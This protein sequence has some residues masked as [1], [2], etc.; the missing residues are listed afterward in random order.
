MKKRLVLFL[1][2][3]VLL[4]PAWVHAADSEFVLLASTIGPIDAGIVG[5]LKCSLKRTRGSGCAMWAP[6]R[7]RP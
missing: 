4:V 1:F 3:L 5:A 2:A 7:G 6:A